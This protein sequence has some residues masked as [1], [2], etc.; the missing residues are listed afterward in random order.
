MKLLIILICTIIVFLTIYFKIS[1]KIEYNYE[2]FNTSPSYII[3][4]YVPTYLERN[5][6]VCYVSHAEAYIDKSFFEQLSLELPL[7]I[8]TKENM[9]YRSDLA[10]LP[11]S[12]LPNDNISNDV[13][14]KI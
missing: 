7:K 12:K 10:I 14:L 3:Y 4:R 2:S 9:K 13:D 11:E 5:P 8:T 6:L 1:D